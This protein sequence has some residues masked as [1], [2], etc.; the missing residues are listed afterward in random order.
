M[1]LKY[2]ISLFLFM[3]LSGKRHNLSKKRL[4]KFRIVL[5]IELGFSV[6]TNCINTM[7]NELK[8]LR[9]L[10]LHATPLST[11]V[12]EMIMH[13]FIS[14]HNTNNSQGYMYVCNVNNVISV[15]PLVQVMTWSMK[16]RNIDAHELEEQEQQQITLLFKVFQ[17]RIQERLHHLRVEM[18][19]GRS[20]SIHDLTC[21]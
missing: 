10:N 17:R 19:L 4:T 3:A 7:E 14:V 21:Y 20:Y 13:Q 1:P 15:F 9:I 11:I 8:S 18:S 2:I 5:P 6:A 16:V 12:E